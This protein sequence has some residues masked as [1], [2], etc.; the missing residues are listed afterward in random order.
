MTIESGATKMTESKTTSR[1][2]RGHGL[3]REGRTG[4]SRH[5]VS[6]GQATCECGERSPELPSTAARQ[7]W[8][9][10]HKAELVRESVPDQMV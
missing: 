2:I 3:L 4:S 10:E 9:R 1:R 6:S 7:R 8:H 5:S